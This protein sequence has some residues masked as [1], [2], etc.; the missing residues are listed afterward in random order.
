MLS[1]EYPPL[2]L[3]AFSIVSLLS[4][5]ATFACLQEIHAMI[6][7]HCSQLLVVS[8]CCLYF[9]VQPGVALRTPGWIT[10][11]EQWTFWSNQSLIR[12]QY[13]LHS[14]QRG[15]NRVRLHSNL[16]FVEMQV[17]CL[18][19]YISNGR[20]SVVRGK[21]FKNTNTFTNI[22]CGSTSVV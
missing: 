16:W 3:Y 22:R 15:L 14:F 19:L 11:P 21:L 8:F 9:F 17:N 20:K 4:S 12:Q 5:M 18:Y 10:A 1:C 13:R 2:P 7:C 6:I